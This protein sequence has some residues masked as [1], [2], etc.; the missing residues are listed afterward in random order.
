MER[1][2]LLG[3]PIDVSNL[4]EV[5]RSIAALALDRSPAMVC[6]SDVNS[7]MTARKS[8]NHMTAFR[9]AAIIT[10][11]GMPI[12]WALRALGHK[13]A[14]R[15][16]GTDLVHAV[17]A[18]PEGHRI[19]HYLYGGATSV[20]EK[21]AHELVKTH[22]INVAGTECPPF[23]PMSRTECEQVRIRIKN[24]GANIVWVGLGCP[25]QERWMLENFQHLNAT[26]V[27]VGAAFDFIARSKTRAPKWMQSAGLEWLHRLATEPQR[28]WRRYLVT[29]A[30]FVPLAL[31]EVAVSHFKR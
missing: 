26:V 16:S 20:A 28:L 10:A 4:S 23:G 17:C 9:S 22:G 1:Q 3:V 25:K 18:C 21:A 8:P 6:V 27:G 31:T 29:A 14:Q 11:D 30:T 13:T 24:S 5:A 15:V 12:I 2:T 19:R 7:L